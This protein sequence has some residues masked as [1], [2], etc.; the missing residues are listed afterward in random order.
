MNKPIFSLAACAYVLIVLPVLAAEPETYSLRYKFQPGETVRWRVE[1]RSMV[2]AAVSTST[3]NTETLSISMKAWRVAEVDA[4]GAATFEHRVEWIDMRQQLTGRDEIRYD[5]RK[6]TAVPPGFEDAAKSVGVPLSVIKIN[7]QGKVLHRERK[8]PGGPTNNDG[9]IT[10]PLPEQ[11][12]PVGHVWSMPLDIDIPLPGGGV[13]RIKAVQQFVL[14]EVKNGVA[15]IRVSTDV[16][17]PITDPAIEAQ[18]V[19]RESSGRVWFDVEAGRVLNQQM[20]TDKHVVGFRG[21][22]SSI[23]YVNRFIERL[24]PAEIRAAGREKSGSR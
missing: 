18:L 21:D 22:A 19:Q 1:H 11:P 10:V 14:E 6:D 8:Q 16:L 24:E 9:W 3:Q 4:D 13:K 2:R 12:V 15:V 23:H 7:A 20:D 5:S 17:T